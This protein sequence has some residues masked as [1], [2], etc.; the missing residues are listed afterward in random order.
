MKSVIE[1][2]REQEGWRHESCCMCNG[3]GMTS[4]FSADGSDFLGPTECRS[5]A[6]NGLYWITPKGRHAE[7]PGGRFV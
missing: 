4:A 6:G 5:C 7:F 1:W 3:T 2:F